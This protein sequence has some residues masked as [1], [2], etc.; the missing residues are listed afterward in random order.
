M[1][2]AFP[3]HFGDE[4]QVA[5]L[6]RGAQTHV[7]TRNDRRYTYYGRTVG[8]TSLDEV[9]LP[10]LTALARLQGNSA[11]AKVADEDVLGLMQR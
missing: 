4:T 2:T 11:Y 7:I 3:D 5:L 9:S 8:A 10:V 1:N 6:D